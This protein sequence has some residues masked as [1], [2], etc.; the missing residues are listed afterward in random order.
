MA[1]Q[2]EAKNSLS[3]IIC[4]QEPRDKADVT[5]ERAEQGSQLCKHRERMSFSIEAEFIYTDHVCR[6]SAGKSQ[7]K[8]QEVQSPFTSFSEHM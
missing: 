1:L 4:D 6:L 3:T 5:R 8:C 7:L 2:P